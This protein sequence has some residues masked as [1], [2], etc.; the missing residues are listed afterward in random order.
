MLQIDSLPY[1]TVQGELLR[2]HER[3]KVRDSHGWLATYSQSFLEATGN[4]YLGR[5]IQKHCQ[6]T[7]KGGVG[8]KRATRRG[9]CHNTSIKKQK[10]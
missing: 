1:K 3:D 6:V 7:Y 2:G 9:S 8:G 10:L 4:Y 5:L